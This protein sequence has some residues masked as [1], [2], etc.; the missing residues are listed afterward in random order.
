MATMNLSQHAPT[1]DRVLQEIALYVK[2]YLVTFV[3]AIRRNFRKPI[4]RPIP[5]GSIKQ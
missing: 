1:H 2:T 3:K 4:T 5:F